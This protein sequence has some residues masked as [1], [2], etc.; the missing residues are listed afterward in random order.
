MTPFI[1][2]RGRHFCKGVFFLFLVVLS[3][4]FFS[5]E[6]VGAPV[7]I[8]ILHVN[9][10][11]GRI[12]PEVEKGVNK[13]RPVGGAAWLAKMVEKERE[14]N[15]GGTLLLS[16][17]DMFQGTAVSRE[18]NGK[19][20]LD[21]M[22]A[23]KFDAMAVGNHEFDWGKNVLAD[24]SRAA[25]FPFL[26]ANIRDGDGKRPPWLKPYVILERKRLKIAV[27]GMTTELTRY[28]VKPEN[29]KGLSFLEAGDALP[30]AIKE[31]KSQGAKTIVVL[32]H[33]G[34]DADKQIAQEIPGIDVIVGGHSH[35]AIT[36][37]VVAGRTIIVQAGCCGHF[38]GV[39]RLKIDPESGRVVE[40]MKTR[41]LKKVYSGPNDPFDPNIAGIVKRYHDRIKDRFSVVVGETAV[42]LVRNYGGES[43]IG[44]LIGDAM[45]EAEKADIA[46]HNSGGIRGNVPAGKITLEQ[47]YAVLPFDDVLVSMDLTGK[48]I[49]LILEQNAAVERGILQVSGLKVK[50]DMTRPVGERVVDVEVGGRP[51]RPGK[52]YRVVTTDFVAAGGKKFAAFGEGK[53]VRYGD[54]MR[55]A[56]VA[57]LKRHSPV[58]PEI[59]GRIVF[60]K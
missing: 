38:L 6:A 49:L 15:P 26:S 22:N 25:R 53:N 41:V 18:F 44:N 48:Q 17:G 9:D 37:P 57:Y 23:M 60:V 40:F 11:H 43:N 3:L 10:T 33:A 29:V 31:A 32:S 35:T 12:L 2:K 46:F 51:L 8:T 58:R 14:K 21:V 50:Y 54:D 39:L 7:G 13:K 42:D 55:D 19:P 34:L 24:L 1:R 56:L 45:R 52:S 27:I 47:L 59:E 28:I 5:A 16:A 36:T 4:T 30:P 20:V